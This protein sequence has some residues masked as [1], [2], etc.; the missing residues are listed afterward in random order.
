MTQPNAEQVSVATDALR[1]EANLWDEQSDN[2]TAL[3]ARVAGMEFGRLEAG[4]FQ[5]MVGPYNDVIHGVA[6]RCAEGATAMTEMA[7]T[8]RSVA[9]TYDAED[10]AGAHRIK[11]IY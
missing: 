6:A 2:L 3:G 7:A 8:L 1:T 10:R 11:K 9:D 5:L 4:L